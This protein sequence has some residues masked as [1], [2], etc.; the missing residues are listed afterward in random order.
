MKKTRGFNPLFLS[1]T[2]I[3]CLI[4]MPIVTIVLEL[5]KPLG[6][7]WDHIVEFMLKDYVKNTVFLLGMVMLI[8]SII[9]TFFSWML[10]QYNYKY[11]RVYYM[12]LVLPMA[13]PTY[14]GGYVYGGIFNFGGTIDRLALKWN[15]SPIRVDILSMGGAIFVFSLFLMP[16]VTLVTR[17]FF[18]RLP[19]S[20]SESSRVLGKSSTE[21]FIKIIL[22]ISR[23]AIFAGAILVGLEILNDYGLVKYFGIQTF[24]TAIF[25]TWFGLG[26]VSSAIRLSGILMVI[27]F[28]LLTL[29]HFSRGRGKVTT[30]SNRLKVK[31][32]PK[33]ANI[34]FKVSFTIYLTFAVII[35][36][37]QLSYWALL[38]KAAQMSDV[39]EIFF[40]TVMLASTVTIIILVSGVVIGHF[41]RMSNTLISKL[42]SKI[43]VLGYSV[44]ASIIAVAVLLFFLFI[45][46]VWSRFDGQPFIS[47]T[48]VMLIFALVIRFMA[49]G[50]N[51]IDSGF[52]KI[53][54]SY[55]HASRLLGK[56]GLKT[57]MNIDL[58]LLKT[59]LLSASILTFVDILKELPLT[60][61]LRPFNFDTLA[62]K[63]F[64]YAG[65]EMIHEASI[66]SLMIIAIS[67]LGIILLQSLVRRSNV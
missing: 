3:A 26:D 16:Y 7:H 34:V 40:N 30:R 2:V 4:L 58:P 29:E 51:N 36:I 55:H 66:F 13:I 23:G 46:R 41:N 5:F 57:F 48:L 49:I 20:F 24:S 6:E 31:K 27:V 18:Q 33:L 17:T 10:T 37:V 22:P 56:S 28:L 19:A 54:T 47:T 25:T 9:G 39:K 44:P 61:I 64:T 67:S 32:A 43:I 38:A 11:K 53:G 1:A 15:F 62:T 12:L 60:L 35:P 45:E 50:F 42:Y 8:T 21:T 52:K 63:V 14:I 59:A 65:D